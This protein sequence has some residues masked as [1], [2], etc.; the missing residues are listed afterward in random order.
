M[1]VD[2]PKVNGSFELFEQV[3]QA[4]IGPSRE[5]LI[6]LCCCYAPVTTK[7]GF[8]KR[9]FVDVIHREITDQEHFVNT[10]VMGSHPIFEDHYQLATCLD[11][12]E[13]LKKDQGQWLVNR[14]KNLADKA[15][16]FTPADPWMM[17][18]EGSIP[19][20]TDP[21]SHKSLWSPEDFEGWASLVYPEYHPTLNIGAFFSWHC[22]DIENDFNRVK[23]ELGIS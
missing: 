5:S 7:F 23:A 2:F 15:I 16:I 17:Q 21:E 19:Y 4:I 6:D 18:P 13:H 22:Q 1:R 11:G 12:I 10:D 9:W 3:L 20:E 14:M 8:K